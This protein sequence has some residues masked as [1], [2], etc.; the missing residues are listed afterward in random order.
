MFICVGQARNR[1]HMGMNSLYNADEMFD[2][3]SSHL[4]GKAVMYINWQGTLS[5]IEKAKGLWLQFGPDIFESI[6]NEHELKLAC[7]LVVKYHDSLRTQS[8]MCEIEDAERCR[9]D[10]ELLEAAAAAHLQD[11]FHNECEDPETSAIGP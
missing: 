5:K 2:R 10:D 3:I 6:G 8:E 1:V 7:R 9:L 11:D 4:T